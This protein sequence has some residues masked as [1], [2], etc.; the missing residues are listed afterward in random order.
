MA[1]LPAQARCETVARFLPGMSATS[2]L[3][4]C[5][6]TTLVL[7][8]AFD[9]SIIAL[10]QAARERSIRIVAVLCDDRSEFPQVHGLDLAL[11]NLADVVVVQT[12]A[13]AQHVR[14]VFGRESTIIEEPYE[15]PAGIPR[16]NPEKT[17]HL[18]WYGRFTNH[19]T[20]AAGILPLI[21]DPALDF[22]LT[23]ITDRMTEH[24]SVLARQ[25]GGR[26]GASIELCPWSFDGQAKALENAD[27]VIIPSLD[28]QDK[29]VKGHNRLVESIRGGV[30]AVAYSLPAYRELSE[31]CWCGDDMHTGLTW[32]V[33]NREAAVDRIRQ[34]Q[35]YIEQRFSIDA[36]SSRWQQL[37]DAA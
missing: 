4:Q 3:D 6:P 20:L 12:T 26:A 10:A 5:R 19:D 1:F 33:A 25:I 36:V 31:F 2:F 21:D 15:M 16:F 24:L 30:L 8:K 35:A 27:M 14:E 22:R 23:V 13:M 34:G 7:T 32:A 28:R 29:R 11:A 17:L 9:P 18:L 37:F